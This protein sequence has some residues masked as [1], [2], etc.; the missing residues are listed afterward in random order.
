MVAALGQHVKALEWL[1]KKEVMADRIEEA[2]VVKTAKEKAVALLAEMQ[3]RLPTK[4]PGDAVA[5]SPAVFPI[6]LL[7]GCALYY[8]F[9]NQENDEV[10]DKSGSGNNGLLKGAVLVHG[11]KGGANAACQ[12]KPGT[13]IDASP[14]D[15]SV[16]P[17]GELTLAA[18]VKTTSSSTVQHLVGRTDGGTTF[19]APGS[20]GLVVGHDVP[21]MPMFHFN[22]GGDQ[23][24]LFGNKLSTNRWHHVVAVLRSGGAASGYIDGV[25]VMHKT[26]FGKIPALPNAYFRLGRWEDNCAYCLT[27]LLDEVRIYRRALTDSEVHQLYNAQKPPP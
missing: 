22:D 9:D 6:G 17:Y 16:A 4:A 26:G 13:S 3:A 2:K 21:L 20:F 25:R 7:K 23:R 5:K 8:T 19:Q 12:F 11:G 24:L 14:S 10:A 18:W 15:D 1:I 27:G